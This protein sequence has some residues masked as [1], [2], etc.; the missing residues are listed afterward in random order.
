[1]RRMNESISFLVSFSICQISLS[2]LNWMFDMGI[3][4]RCCGVLVKT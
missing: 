4:R 1:M 3:D 2:A